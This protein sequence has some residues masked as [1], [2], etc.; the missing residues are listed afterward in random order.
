MWTIGL[1]HW[2]EF[3]VRAV[4]VYT[5]LLVILRFTGK[6]QVGQLAPFDLVLLLILSNAVQNAMNGGDNSITGG[7]ILATT[8]VA[9][10]WI[11]GWL[12]Y[13]SKWMEVLIEGQPLMLVHDGKINPRAL[14][15]V[16]MTMHELRAALRAS[17]C[18]CEDEVRFAVLE[19]NGHV[20]VVPKGQN[21]ADPKKE[22]GR[23]SA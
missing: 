11:V 20:T 9:L 5:F 2:S 21:H 8:L 13:R 15:S 17:G 10:N 1:P 3:I 14:K 19:N 6:R 23:D 16:Q 18:A 4:V 7:L 12:T 22:T